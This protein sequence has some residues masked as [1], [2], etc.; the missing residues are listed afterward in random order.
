MAKKKKKSVALESVKHK[1]SVVDAV[2]KHKE[3][4]GVPIAAFFDQAALK[5][6]AHLEVREKEQI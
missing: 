2:R 6:L 5:E 3:K 1:K 4:S